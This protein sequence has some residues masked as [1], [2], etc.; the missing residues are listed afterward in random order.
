MPTVLAVGSWWAFVLR[1][2]LTLLFGML[3]LLL[4]E[5]AVFTLVMA[6]GAFALASGVFDIVAA[7]REKAPGP[8]RSWA[9]FALGVV[10]ILAGLVAFA[11]PGLTAVWLLYLIATWALVTGILEIVAAVRLRKEI[12]GEWLLVGSGVLSVGFGALLVAFPSAG[13]LAVLFWIGAYAILLGVMLVGLGMELRRVGRL[14]PTEL[15]TPAAAGTG[16]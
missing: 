6:F 10:S 1:G 8:R 3:A 2:V 14:G 5:M 4:P 11:R 16:R 12:R 13:A 7:L 15:E 9:L